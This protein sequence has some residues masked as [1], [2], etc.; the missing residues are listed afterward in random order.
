[1]R[2][3]MNW[4]THCFQT[5]GT[6]AQCKSL[7]HFKHYPAVRP[8]DTPQQVDL[9]GLAVIKL[10]I[11]DYKTSPCCQAIEHPV[12]DWPA[13]PGCSPAGLAGGRQGG[14]QGG[15]PGNAGQQQTWT[16]GQQRLQPAVATA[17]EGHLQMEKALVEGPMAKWPLQ[18]N[19]L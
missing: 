12:T 1:M 10:Y 9:H 19:T 6:S 14:T 8:L 7:L 11:N 3:L 18:Q 16:S 15:T 5:K 17:W 4:T 2:Y 13:W